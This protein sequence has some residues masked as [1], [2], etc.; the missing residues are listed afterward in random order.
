MVS[1]F[2]ENFEKYKDFILEVSVDLHNNALMDDD[3]FYFNKYHTWGDVENITGWKIRISD[4]SIAVIDFDINKDLN[5]VLYEYELEKLMNDLEYDLRNVAKNTNSI[6][7][8]TASNS[9]HLYCY[10]GSILN[11]FEYYN[12]RNSY[13]KIYQEFIMV[14]DEKIGFFDIDLFVPTKNTK[15]SPN[16][17][18]LPGSRAKN[19][20]GEIGAY[21]V[22]EHKVDSSKK[23]GDIFMVWMDLQKYCGLNNIQDYMKEIQQ[24]EV[25]LSSISKKNIT[26][27]SNLMTKRLF[28]LIKYGFNGLIIHNYANSI[29]KE[30]SLYPLVTALNACVNKEITNEDV[31]EFIDYVHKNAKLTPNAEKSFYS[32]MTLSDVG[33]TPFS[34]VKMLKYHNPDYYEKKIKKV[35]GLTISKSKER[36]EIY[37]LVDELYNLSK[38]TADDVDIIIRSIYSVKDKVLDED[39]ILD[40]LDDIEC[41]TN[42][43]CD[44]SISDMIDN[45]LSKGLL[46]IDSLRKLTKSELLDRNIIDEIINGFTKVDL[47][48]KEVKL[49][50]SDIKSLDI[51][52]NDDIYKSLICDLMVK[53]NS[54]NTIIKGMSNEIDIYEKPN[55]SNTLDI[56]KYKNK[57]AYNNITKKLNI[58]TE[59]KTGIDLT[60]DFT[61]SD[62]GKNCYISNG[63]IDF[64]KLFSDVSRTIIAISETR[65]IYKKERI[66]KGEYKLTRTSDEDIKQISKHI[67]IKSS[68]GDRTNISLNDILF[69][70]KYVSI[71]NDYIDRYSKRNVSFYSKDPETFSI[72]GG[73]GYKNSDDV[74]MASISPFLD[75]VENIIATDNTELYSYILKWVSYIIQNPGKRTNSCL[76]LVGEQGTGKTTFVNTIC[77]LFGV[78]AMTNS[79]RLDDIVGSFNG[80]IEGKMII[81]MN[82]LSAAD[83]FSFN[84][85]VKT[86]NYIIESL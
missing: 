51:C 32:T 7:V 70:K 11:E 31:S 1:E 22:I 61:I 64:D 19:K 35:Y 66:A 74:D 69:G 77:K 2:S 60:D 65:F 46:N 48:E 20:N 42:Y 30:I 33:D 52:K 23:L 56:L 38:I 10:G 55:Y 53:S 86:S 44:E 45:S 13:T 25:D 71:N 26:A 3:C 12:M 84:G 9:Y 15:G 54:V 34:L 14:D 72:F 83:H 24:N 16:G 29:N 49:I 79:Q 59:Y 57:E 27:N 76:V 18:M 62:I 81:V 67:A 63:I 47:D 40:I 75:F 28:D 5:K 37:N 50:L 8:R 85:S 43:N 80:T 4:N 78:Y 73:F 82:E 39:E 36:E 21:E 17:V 41:G 6:L 68:D 58:K